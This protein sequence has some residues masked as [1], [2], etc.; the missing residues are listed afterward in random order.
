MVNYEK[1]PVIPERISILMNVFHTSQPSPSASFALGGTL[2]EHVCHIKLK[3]QE[4][5]RYSM[6]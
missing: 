4:E 3:K 2:S 5:V 1:R 6:T